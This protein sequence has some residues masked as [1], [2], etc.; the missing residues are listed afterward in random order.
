MANN[1]NANKLS[2]NNMTYYWTILKAIGIG[3]FV[4]AFVLVVFNVTGA[5]FFKTT[6]T[7]NEMNIGNINL[8][9]TDINNPLIYT[10]TTTVLPITVTNLSNT[11]VVIRAY[12]NLYWEEGFPLGDVDIILANNDWTIG[13]DGYFYYNF[14]LTPAGG[15]NDEANFLNSVDI[16]DITGEKL[17]TNFFVNIYFE[18]AQYAN[19]GYA[20][21]WTTA[22]ESWLNV[23]S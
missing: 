20:N 10:T 13:E 16:F 18:G 12:F 22:P 15:I 23:L 5:W 2:I 14:V 7:E 8:V 1:K 4:S 11:H 17:N 21:L 3:F 19:S 6:V 9:A